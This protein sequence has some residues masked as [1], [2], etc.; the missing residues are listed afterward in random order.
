MEELTATVR[1]NTDSARAASALADAALDATRH[2]GGVVDS[3][4]DRMRGIA[5][6]SGRIAEII[7]VIDGI[8]FQTNILALNA[9]VE[10]ARA[11]E[12]GRGFAVVAG[13]VRSLAQRS[14][15][16]A[17]EI[18]ALIEESVAQIDGGSELVER[19]GDAMRTVSASITR[20][21]Q[22]MSEITAAS[23]EQSVGIEQ[24]NQAVTQMDQLTQQ[25]AALVEEV[26]AAAASLNEQT[27]HLMQAVSVFELGDARATRGV[28]EVRDER[29]PSFAD[30]GYEA[31]GSAA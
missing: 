25:N 9:A 15:Q 7:S 8:A 1:Q 3:V 17:K 27:A 13:E 2:G 26:A 31:A 20:V 12:Q 23:V 14:A 21:A 6:S 30:D 18:K 4:I 5:K 28:R 16:S 19:A 29:A 22:T 11:G 24:V 10:A